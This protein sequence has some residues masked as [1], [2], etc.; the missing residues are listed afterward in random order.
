[1]TR[2]KHPSRLS[3]TACVRMLLYS[4]VRRHVCDLLRIK[5]SLRDID[6]LL[7]AYTAGT[8]ED[9]NLSEVPCFHALSNRHLPWCLPHTRL[10]PQEACRIGIVMCCVSQRVGA[11]VDKCLVH[12]THRFTHAHRVV[13]QVR[14][15]A[16]RTTAPLLSVK[17][18]TFLRR[19]PPHHNL[20]FKRRVSKSLFGFFGTTL[21]NFS[22]SFSSCLSFSR[23]F[24]FLPVFIWAQS[25]FLGERCSCCC[26]CFM[27]FPG[28]LIP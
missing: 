18:L 13:L 26:C 2:V 28:T 8:T 20:L 10:S 15:D 14:S 1:M 9:R 23:V 12:T 25:C 7:V 21:V 4:C 27:L 17:Q 6:L 3:V 5:T 19:K 11:F 24:C 22:T 16:L